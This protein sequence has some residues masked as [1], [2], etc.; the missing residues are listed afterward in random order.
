[1][2]DLASFQIIDKSLMIKP[3]GNGRKP[4][5]AF[6]LVREPRRFESISLRNLKNIRPFN[7]MLFILINCKN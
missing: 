7:E 1:M 2:S 5:F 6:G 3:V 4:T